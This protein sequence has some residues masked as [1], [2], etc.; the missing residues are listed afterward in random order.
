[1]YFTFS[2]PEYLWYLLSIPLLIVSHYAFLKYARRRAIQFAN[3]QA[4][5]RVSEQKIVTRNHAILIIR[6]IILF[7]LIIAISGTTIWY[8]GLTNDNDVILTIDISSSMTAQDFTPS[9]LEAAKEYMN[10]FVDRIESDS[11]IGVVSF[12]GAAFIECLPTNN[13]GKVKEAIDNIIITSASGT[14]IPDAIITSSN[15]LLSSDKGKTII[16][17]TDGSNTLSYF[18]KDPIVEGIKYA[19]EN[20][21]IIYTI[22]IGSN[23]EPIGYLPEYYNISAVYDEA[24]LIKI[25]NETGGMYY[26]AIDSTQLSE[27]YSN[28][29]SRTREA[30]LNKDL[31]GGLMII[32]LAFIFLEWG[33]ISTRFRAIPR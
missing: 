27:A 4:L 31:S 16:L 8:K 2:R 14:N 11:S 29:L 18:T 7:S 32:A 10:L 15:L 20:N 17:L 24:G 12:A 26:N 19:K 23:T 1:M 3:F 5:K 6:I 30:Y 22:G 9:R 25:A 21:V 33:L 28:I 13:K